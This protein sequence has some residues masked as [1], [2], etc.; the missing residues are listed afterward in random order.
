MTAHVV[1]TALDPA[2]PATTS[3]AC[4]DAIRH[5]IGFGGLL[6]TDDI[7]MGALGGPVSDR[8]RDAV[9]AGCDIVLHC[10]GKL[11]EMVAVAEASG[12]LEGAAAAR[13]EAARAARRPARPA[14]E[15]ALEAELRELMAEADG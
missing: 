8:C 2:A 13:A 7:S 12:P 14:D 15:A 5:R 10:N 3:P 11:D 6:M 4:I 1:Y 9:A